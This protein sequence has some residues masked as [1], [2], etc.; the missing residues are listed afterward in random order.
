MFAN[1]RQQ[2]YMGSKTAPSD[3]PVPNW[4]GNLLK[5][6]CNLHVGRKLDRLLLF[7]YHKTRLTALCPELPG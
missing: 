2:E 4:G 1:C 7:N 3:L 6:F 5:L